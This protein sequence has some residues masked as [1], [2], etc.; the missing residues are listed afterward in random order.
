MAVIYSAGYAAVY[1]IFTLMYWHAWRRRDELDLSDI[2]QLETRYS[3]VENGI[4]LGVASLAILIATF[5][6]SPFAMFA[7]FL[8]AP[9]QTILGRM[10]SRARTAIEAV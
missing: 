3:I 1:A 6:R 10:R 5:A 4:Y 9:L 2:E 7:C 8:I